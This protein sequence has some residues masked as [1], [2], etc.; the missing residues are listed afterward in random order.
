[1]SKSR[2]IAL[3]STSKLPYYDH[4]LLLNFDTQLISSHFLIQLQKT[5]IVNIKI[6]VLFHQIYM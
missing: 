2:N 3:T 5:I 6:I 4:E 1:M